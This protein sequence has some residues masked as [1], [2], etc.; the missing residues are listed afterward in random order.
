MYRLLPQPSL[1]PPLSKPDLGAL[2]SLCS[3]S[4][5]IHPR[6]CSIHVFVW[7]FS[8]INTSTCFI[9]SRHLNPIRPNRARCFQ[10]RKTQRI[11]DSF[12]GKSI[13]KTDFRLH[14]MPSSLKHF[15]SQL[16]CNFFGK[17]CKIH[18]PANGTEATDPK[19]GHRV[20]SAVGRVSTSARRRPPMRGEENKLSAGRLDWPPFAKMIDQKRVTFLI[21]F[22]LFLNLFYLVSGRVDRVR[23]LLFLSRK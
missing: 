1:T 19:V 7:F 21:L 6:L 4:P 3:P 23:F 22:H 13:M 20:D 2:V 8:R 17:N 18:I 12:L 15:D 11:V 14:L 5:L 16:L 10:W 9:E